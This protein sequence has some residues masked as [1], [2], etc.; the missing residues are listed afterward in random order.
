MVS[1]IHSS[2]QIWNQ[3]TGPIE[4]RKNSK[5]HMLNERSGTPIGPLRA[6]DAL[7]RARVPAAIVGGGKS[8]SARDFR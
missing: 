6:H 7:S 4:R 2:R 3:R 1:T 5:T 8:S